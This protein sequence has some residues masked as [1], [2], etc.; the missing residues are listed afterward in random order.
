VNIPW[1][2]V[3]DHMHLPSILVPVKEND[4]DDIEFGPSNKEEM[5]IGCW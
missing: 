1:D 5:W 4:W 2:E 3:K